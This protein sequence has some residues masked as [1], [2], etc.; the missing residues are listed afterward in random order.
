[1]PTQSL[2][3]SL[4]P[5]VTGGRSANA[6]GAQTAA[7]AAAW[8]H[9]DLRYQLAD[10]GDRLPVLASAAAPIAELADERDDAAAV[11][12]LQAA[13][14]PAQPIGRE[15]R[16]ALEADERPAITRGNQPQ[17]PGAAHSVAN[18]FVW[19]GATPHATVNQGK[20]SHRRSFARL[21]KNATRPTR[22]FGKSSRSPPIWTPRPGITSPSTGRC[23]A[24]H[25]S[26]RAKPG[27]AD[28]G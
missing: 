9:T 27:S 14:A 8:R 22:E 13:A 2:A 19:A 24:K 17:L 26:R 1:M 6:Y 7:L 5:G 4:T 18:A 28:P 20:S 12:E 11:G 10:R 21:H 16:F 23:L 3:R 15:H 25:G